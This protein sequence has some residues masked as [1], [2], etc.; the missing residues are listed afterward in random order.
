[1]IRSVNG[2]LPFTKFATCLRTN[3]EVLHNILT[4][5][6]AGRAQVSRTRRQ[7]GGA[8]TQQETRNPE[9]LGDWHASLSSQRP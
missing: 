1:M 2:A 5:I 3:H 7:E 4:T 8:E 9:G 6:V